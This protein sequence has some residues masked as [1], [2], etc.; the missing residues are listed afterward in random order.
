MKKTYQNSSLR[1]ILKLFLLPKHKTKG[2]TTYATVEQNLG[3]SGGLLMCPDQQ[4]YAVFKD[5]NLL[6]RTK[7]MKTVVFCFSMVS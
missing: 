5:I 1:F 3:S 7:I 6:E 4:K 2:M